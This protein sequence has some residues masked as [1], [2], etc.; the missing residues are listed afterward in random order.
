MWCRERERARPRPRGRREGVSRADRPV[1]RRA[2]AALLPNPRLAPG[3]RGRR[4][5]DAARS[6]ARAARVRGTRLTA[7]M[8]LPDRDE[9]VPERA[10]RPRTPPEGGAC[11][12]RAAGADAKDRA[13]VAGAL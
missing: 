2:A 12:G 1:P 10:S 9:P 6:L 3:C 5:G 13:D 8:A 11:D 4:A 7:R